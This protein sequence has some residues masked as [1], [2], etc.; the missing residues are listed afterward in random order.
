MQQKKKRLR[1]ERRKGKNSMTND[2]ILIEAIGGDKH[3]YLCGHGLGKTVTN[4][5]RVKP[6]PLDLARQL[7]DL[8]KKAHETAEKPQKEM[9]L[10]REEIDEKLS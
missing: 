10:A 7:V 9:E 2:H 4:Y 1:K 8:K 3:G 5:H 6:S